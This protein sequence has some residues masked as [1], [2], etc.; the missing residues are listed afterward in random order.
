[1]PDACVPQLY[2]AGIDLDVDSTSIKEIQPEHVVTLMSAPNPKI[3]RCSCGL[4]KKTIS[5]HFYITCN[6]LI[7]TDG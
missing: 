7:S 4:A 2:G 1:M 5:E 3:N 6:S